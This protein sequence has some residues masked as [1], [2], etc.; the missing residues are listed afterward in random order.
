MPQAKESFDCLSTS[1]GNIL[2]EDGEREKALD[3]FAGLSDLL[4]GPEDIP[5]LPEIVSARA[6]RKR[7]NFPKNLLP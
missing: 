5:A 2:L 7:L 4:D 1:L 3:L 6:T